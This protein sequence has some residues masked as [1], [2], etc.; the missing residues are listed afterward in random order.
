MEN[1]SSSS[2]SLLLFALVVTTLGWGVVDGASVAAA[3]ETSVE[4]STPES[5][6]IVFHKTTY[7][8]NH[9]NKEEM[10][11]S[12]LA[13]GVKSVTNCFLRNSKSSHLCSLLLL[14]WCHWRCWGCPHWWFLRY[15]WCLWC[16]WFWLWWELQWWDYCY[17]F[18]HWRTGLY[19]SM[20]DLYCSV[21]DPI[22]QPLWQMPQPSL[23][24]KEKKKKTQ[25]NL[26]R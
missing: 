10:A 6:R 22:Y 16:W 12:R 8:D 2:P 15:L 24:K 25:H 3:W 20:T 18:L 1:K 19:C 14:M 21:T 5:G 11:M 13:T 26:V 9:Q 7:R 4:L 17:W 23:K